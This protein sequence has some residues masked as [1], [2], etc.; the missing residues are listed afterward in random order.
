[1]RELLESAKCRTAPNAEERQMPTGAKCRQAQ[2]NNGV[3]ADCAV[4][5]CAAI[6]LRRLATRAPRHFAP[7]GIWRSSRF[8][9]FHGIGILYAAA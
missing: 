7:F 1:M 3:R 8:T 6:A 9:P 2:G 4:G 5:L